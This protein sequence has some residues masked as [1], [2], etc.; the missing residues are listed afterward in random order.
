MVDVGL[1]RDAVQ[2]R[3][4]A[5]LDGFLLSP[6]HKY[7]VDGFPG[8]GSRAGDVVLRG[9]GA[10]PHIK[11]AKTKKATA[12]YAVEKMEGQPSIGNAH[13]LV[14]HRG[15]DYGH[16]L[17]ARRPCVMTSLLYKVLPGQ[18]GYDRVR[19]I[20]LNVCPV[21]SFYIN[22]DLMRQIDRWVGKP[23]CVMLWSYDRV[24][25]DTLRVIGEI[26]RIGID[27]TVNLL[28]LARFSTIPAYLSGASH[29]VGFG[30]LLARMPV[31]ALYGPEKPDVFVPLTENAEVLHLDL[32]N[33]PC[34]SVYNRKPSP[35]R[36]N[37]C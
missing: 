37:Q 3:L 25:R 1:H 9:T 14:K 10:G 29:R 13:H 22:P 35:C 20:N 12:G 7:P 26:R 27:A 30:A 16:G 18:L 34:V 21:Y 19:F 15:R 28:A 11:G 6:P 2:T 23:L 5:S 17:H 8:A 36:V 31:L 32:A 4:T 24:A 33:F